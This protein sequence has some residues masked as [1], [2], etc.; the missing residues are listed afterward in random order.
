MG[1]LEILGLRPQPVSE[2]VERFLR[3]VSLPV[4]ENGRL[5]DDFGDTPVDT[6][7]G[8]KPDTTSD[9]YNDIGAMLQRSSESLP[10]HPLGKVVDV[11]K[12]H[13]GE[14]PF[15]TITREADVP[16]DFVEDLGKVKGIFHAEQRGDQV[17][18][19]SPF[20]KPP[21]EPGE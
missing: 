19:S 2:E 1:L 11:L 17:V 3:E 16:P 15:E 10:D 14:A 12:E 8:D 21:E 20:L 13:G 4:N 18:F 6:I 5:L 7:N 9:S